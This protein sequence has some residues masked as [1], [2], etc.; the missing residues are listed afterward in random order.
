MCCQPVAPRH[1]DTGVCVVAACY[2]HIAIARNGEV[3]ITYRNAF[4]CSFYRFT[5]LKRSIRAFD[6]ETVSI[7]VLLDM[8]VGEGMVVQVPPCA[9]KA[10]GIREGKRTQLFLCVYN[11]DFITADRLA[12]YC[13]PVCGRINV[14]C[15]CVLKR[16][17]V[18]SV[19]LSN[20][21]VLVDRCGYR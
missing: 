19:C 14:P 20:K 4:L 15:C 6:P 17:C 5:E 2:P 13:N 9:D 8:S 21:R 10:G 3:S 12:N 1:V 16:I 18:R 11:A 7:I